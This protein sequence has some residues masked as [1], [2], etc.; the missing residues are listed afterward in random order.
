MGLL[1]LWTSAKALIKIFLTACVVFIRKDTHALGIPAQP[2]SC[3][4]GDT[5]PQLGAAQLQQS[6]ELLH[7]VPSQ[8]PASFCS[9]NV[10]RPRHVGK[11]EV[12][13]KAALGRENPKEGEKNREEAEISSPGSCISPSNST[14][15]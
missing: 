8:T 12:L 2:Q 9:C 7:S 15:S 5:E 10:Q 1:L 13:S 14:P 6:F 4:A 11:L 3:K